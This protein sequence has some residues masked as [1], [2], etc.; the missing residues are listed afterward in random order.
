MFELSKAELKVLEELWYLI[1]TKRTCQQ[2]LTE[3]ADRV[4]QPVDG[5]APPETL[6]SET[7]P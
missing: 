5:L 2:P 1:Q 3:A 6:S 4:S 7:P